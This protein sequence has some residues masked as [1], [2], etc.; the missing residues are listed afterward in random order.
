MSLNIIKTKG[1][2]NFNGQNRSSN[3]NNFQ[4]PNQ[5]H[6]RNY[7][8]YRIISNNSSKISQNSVS[9]NTTQN[10][11]P[12][13]TPQECSF[14]KTQTSQ[15]LMSVEK[16]L[17]TSFLRILFSI[18]YITTALALFFLT[19]FYEAKTTKAQ[20]IF[21]FFEKIVFA[22]GFISILLFM[23]TKL[24][25]LMLFSLFFLLA[26][27]FENQY[28]ILKAQS[29]CFLF[30]PSTFIPLVSLHILLSIINIL[31]TWLYLENFIILPIILGFIGFIISIIL[32]Q[33]FSKN[34]TT[35]PL[36]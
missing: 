32:L 34:S 11:I 4:K 2:S 9:Q 18:L 26:V 27:M 15:N 3:Y 19:M 23:K 35:K 6:N 7:Q 20:K 25:N 24:E 1:S 14:T 10:G 12:S 30:H 13:G 28:S 36:I 29:S 33:A 21:F 5:F 8:N 22:I 17:A 31:A 16:N